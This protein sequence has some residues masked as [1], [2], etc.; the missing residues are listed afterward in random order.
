MSP[1]ATCSAATAVWW[2][3][4]STCSPILLDTR[5]S[6]AISLRSVSISSSDR[7]LKMLAEAS[8]PIISATIAALRRPDIVVWMFTSPHLFLHPAAEDL[9]H[10]FRLLD[11]AVR[12]ALGQHRQLAVALGC[13]GVELRF[14]LAFELGHRPWP[15]AR[16]GYRHPRGGDAGRRPAHQRLD[17]EEEREHD[18]EEQPRHPRRFLDLRLVAH[19]HA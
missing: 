18:H 9:G 6:A 3:S 7:C 4:S 12:D 8:S 13:G 1:R 10:V 16:G 14:D 2:N 15:R 19:E 17:D 5:P 11:R